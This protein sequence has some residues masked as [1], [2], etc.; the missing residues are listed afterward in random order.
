VGENLLR[1]V[2]AVG[3]DGSEAADED[4]ADEEG[5]VDGSAVVE[6]I[7]LDFATHRQLPAQRV[8]KQ[9]LAELLQ[10]PNGIRV[11]MFMAK[12]STAKLI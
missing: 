2:I 4:L 5:A 7:P 8:D 9:P 11:L 1:K 10:P 12:Y 6:L 3:P